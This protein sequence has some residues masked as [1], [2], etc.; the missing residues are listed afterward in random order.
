MVIRS[1]EHNFCQD[2]QI[3]ESIFTDMKALEITG[4]EILA[5]GI[6]QSPAVGIL[7]KLA[8]HNFRE[9][10]REQFLQKL[11]D[12]VADP[13]GFL[14]DKKWSKIAREFIVEEEPY[15]ALQP[16]L[17]FQSFG[18]EFIE[19]GARLQMSVAMQLPVSVAGALMP[20]AH[21][22][23]GLPIGGVLA[24]RDAVIPY[25]VGVDIGCRMSLSIYDIK[26]DDFDRHQA[27]FK[28]ELIAHTAF[29]AGNGFSGSAKADHPVL[30]DPKF[31]ATSL[32]RSL[33]DKAWSQLGSSGSGNHFVEFGILSLQEADAEL[34]L[35]AGRYLALLS[36]SGSRGLGATI[37]NH[38]T[39][40]AKSQCLLPPEAAHLAWF[41]MDSAAGQ[42]Y[43]HAMNLAGE[44]AA[45][46]HD[47]IHQKISAAIGATPLARVENHH[48]FAWKEIYKGEELIVHRKGATP[49]GKGVAGII[50]GSMTA[51]GYLVRGLGN[52]SSIQSASHG[53]GRKMSRSRA[54]KEFNQRDLQEELKR[55][56]V[57][58]IGGGI[59]EAPGAY[60]NIRDVM[61]AQKDLVEIIASFSPKLVIMDR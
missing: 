18:D 1:H 33:R 44:Y 45:A 48:N 43:W 35:E 34:R 24:V 36:H 15:I 60:K 41:E 9:D 12:V 49:A 54:R 47:I 55:N 38:Y 11:R 30:T 46:N 42:E 10:Q 37:A 58:L 21:H 2:Q 13:A 28:R 17:A 51:P 57:T 50:P 26:E 25:G 29:G 16:D 14:E 40:L 39:K 20:D 19:E 23:Y 6:K 22:G 52:P 8:G 59:D 31:E 27:K 5:Q 7:I 53:A 56:G 61:S 32:T 3:K 4:E